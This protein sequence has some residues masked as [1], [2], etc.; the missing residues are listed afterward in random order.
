MFLIHFLYELIIV[1]FIVWFV[2]SIIAI[3]ILIINVVSIILL[4]IIIFMN[5]HFIEL[6]IYHSFIYL[7]ILLPTKGYRYD[8]D[9]ALIFNL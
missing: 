6:I 2:L 4:L 7:L 8:F 3:F 9:F 1:T 5:I